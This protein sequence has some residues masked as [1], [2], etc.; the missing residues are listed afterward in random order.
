MGI[1]KALVMTPL[2]VMVRGV[3]CLC[4][5]RNALP[6]GL[7]DVAEARQLDPVRD[8]AGAPS[9]LPHGHDEL[10]GHDRAVVLAL[11]VHEHRLV[12]EGL[13][14]EVLSQRSV[15]D[16]SLQPEVPFLGRVLD[17]DRGEAALDVPVPLE[18]IPGLHGIR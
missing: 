12:Q 9:C 13:R 10:L 3:L 7:L 1:C 15:L 4:L 14:A 5:L 16:A 8:V 11:E 2:V 18:S 6:M 17:R